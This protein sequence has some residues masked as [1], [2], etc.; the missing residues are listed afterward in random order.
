[1]VND[2]RSV[3]RGAELELMSILFAAFLALVC[4]AGLSQLQAA[5]LIMFERP[6]CP[7]CAAFD[8]KIG[9]VYAKTREGQ[10]APLRRIDVT[11]A[12]PA[13]LR[14][15]TI[16]RVTP[17]FVL[18]DQGREVGRIRGYPGENHFWGLLGELIARLDEPRPLSS[19]KVVTA[20][21]ANQ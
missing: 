12:I 14:F 4:S 10:R 9:P 8:R 15:V 18:L 7:W 2:G 1:M 16:E 6:G 17:V 20:P 11:Q 13:E 19:G 21:G 3:G 5:E